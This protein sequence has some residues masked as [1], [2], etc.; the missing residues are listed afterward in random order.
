MQIKFV[1]YDQFCAE[2]LQMNHWFNSY[3]EWQ[4][5]HSGL[6]DKDIEL[7]KER[8]KLDKECSVEQE[9]EFSVI[10]ARRDD[11]NNCLQ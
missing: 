5:E 6:T 2:Q 7:W 11:K 3:W 4:L 9:V 1:N 8:R 10:V